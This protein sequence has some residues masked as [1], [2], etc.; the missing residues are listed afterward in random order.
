MICLFLL[1]ILMAR[2]M[3]K[4]EDEAVAVIIKGDLAVRE[5]LDEVGL[6]FDREKANLLSNNPVALSRV[7]QMF[8]LFGGAVQPSTKRLGI[9]HGAANPKAAGRMPVAKGRIAKALRRSLRLNSVVRK[10]DHKKT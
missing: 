6:S 5:A 7:R 4:T 3:K 1:T 8:G 9:D 2:Q 10:L